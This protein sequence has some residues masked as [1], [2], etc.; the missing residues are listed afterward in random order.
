MKSVLW[1]V[2]IPVALGFV[3]AEGDYYGGRQ[4]RQF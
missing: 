4:K 2:I 1:R 3:L